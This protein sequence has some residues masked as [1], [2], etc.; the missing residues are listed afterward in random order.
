MLMKTPLVPPSSADPAKALSTQ[1]AMNRVLTPSRRIFA[2]PAS[3]S[4]RSQ[5]AGSEQ[6]KRF[7]DS[8]PTTTASLPC[9]ITRRAWR[10][11][12]TSRNQP[13][14]GPPLWAST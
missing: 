1:W 8:T 5:P 4:A 9:S 6:P 13:L 7:E 3:T 2:R 12:R 10:G 11:L 14:P